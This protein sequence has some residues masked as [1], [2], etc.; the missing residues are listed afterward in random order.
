MKFNLESKDYLY[1]G[2]FILLVIWIMRTREQMTDTTDTNIRDMVKEVYQVDVQAIK[3]LGDLAK[4]IYSTGEE[5]TLEL[6][7]NLKING[8][9]IVDGTSTFNNTITSKNISATGNV[10]ATGNISATGNVSSTGYITAEKDLTAKGAIYAKF[11]RFGEVG[12]GQ[13]KWYNAPFQIDENGRLNKINMNGDIIMNGK[14][15]LL[16]DNTDHVIKY[17]NETEGV[18][19][20]GDKITLRNTPQTDCQVNV[21][22]KL[23]NN[24]KEVLTNNTKV[25]IYTYGK[26][27]HAYPSFLQVNNSYIRPY[28]EGKVPL[29][30]TKIG[31]WQTFELVKKPTQ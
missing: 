24:D 9:L 18:L 1:L 3:N 21:K 2:L 29:D 31:D 22:G 6:P 19:I 5:G 14:N 8:N 4:Q 12:E 26:E 17:S 28:T 27:G 7:G 11:G 30:A 20:K 15:I 16:K 25:G 13:S 10:S 23:H